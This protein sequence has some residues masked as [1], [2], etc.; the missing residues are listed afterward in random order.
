[1]DLLVQ[2]NKQRGQYGKEFQTFII[3]K[4]WRSQT[5]IFSERKFE[6]ML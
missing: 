5:S 6:E 2:L 4:N 3:E 1:M